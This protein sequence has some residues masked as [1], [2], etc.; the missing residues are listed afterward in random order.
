MSFRADAIREMRF[1]DKL[2]GS[3]PGEDIDFCAR[4]PEGSTLLIAPRARLVHNRSP[5]GR[6]SSHWLSLHSQVSSYMRERHWKAGLFNNLFYLWLSTGYVAAA[7]ISCLK[8]MSWEPLQAWREGAR[9]GASIAA[10]DRL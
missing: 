10:G 1:D 8:R 9:K 5:K 4:L 6:S 2:T 7:T 3:S